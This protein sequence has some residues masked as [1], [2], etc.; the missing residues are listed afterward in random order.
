[1]RTRTP[2]LIALLLLS[3]IVPAT[4]PELVTDRPDQT[5]STE[6]VP[7]GFV[8]TE[9]GFGDADHAEATAAGLARIG[10]SSRVELRVGLDEIFLSGPEDAI[11]LSLGA[12]IRLLEERDRRPALAVIAALNQ[13]AGDSLSPL[14][15]GLRPSF[16]FAASHTLSERLSL[17]YNAGVAW[18]ES[19]SFAGMPAVPDKTLESRF[20]WTAALGIGATERIGF[21]VEAF[22]D[23]GLSD[24]GP[25]E[26]S[27]DGGMTFLVRPNVQLDVFVGTGIS[28]AAPDWLAGLGVSFRL[29]R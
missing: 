20:L 17:A 2:I 4:E 21:F 11:D 13:K 22:G 29:P 14:S 7:R 23:S 3:P 16:R 24:D 5:E 27:I 6:I 18:D 1:M 15:D 19:V 12:K 8:Q 9:L 25:T 28:N 26:T 10:L